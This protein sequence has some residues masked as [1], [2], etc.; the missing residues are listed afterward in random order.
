MKRE[1]TRGG[2]K[3]RGIIIA[4]NGVSDIALNT[5]KSESIEV[6]DLDTITR[7]IKHQSFGINQYSL[8]TIDD[9]YW[10]EFDGL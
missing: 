10:S 8:M 4:L 7:M 3:I 9:A 1:E 2:E 6:W 5:A